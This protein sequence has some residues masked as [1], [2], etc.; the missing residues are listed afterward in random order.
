MSFSCSSEHQMRLLEIF[1]NAPRQ[2]YSEISYM[3]H[4]GLSLAISLARSS[5]GRN[6]ANGQR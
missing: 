1:E 6:A 2:K 3:V 5:M 4:G